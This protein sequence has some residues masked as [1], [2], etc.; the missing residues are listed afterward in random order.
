MRKLLDAA[1]AGDEAAVQALLEHHI[2]GLRAFVRLRAGEVVRRKESTSDLVQSVCLETLREMGKL[3]WRGEAAFRS[4]LFKAAERKIIDRARFWRA[5]QR[6]VG[7]EQEPSTDSRVRHE[8]RLRETYRAFAQPS[9][10]ASLR[11]EIQRV[12]QAFERL[13]EHHREVITL[14]KIVGLSRAEIAE[15]T[16]RSEGAVR[17]LLH[18]ALAELSEYLT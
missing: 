10:E 6:D 18:R 4:W 1:Q 16:G 15:Q 13:P 5:A 8:A 3:Q 11:D 7:R 12:E 2:P 9:E 17:V 14:A